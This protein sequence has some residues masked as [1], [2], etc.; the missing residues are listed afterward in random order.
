VAERLDEE[1]AALR[2][3]PPGRFEPA[4]ERAVRVPIDG[5]LKHAGSFYRA[6][7]KLVH[8]RVALRFSRD[9]IWICHRGAEV[10]RYRRSYER[11]TWL[12]APVVRPEPPPARAPALL[13]TI[14]I[15]PPELAPY[16]ELVR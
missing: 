8:Q 11:G 15:P 5:Y 12:P 4:G 13:P 3:L 10:A 6:P 1:R 9:E 14:A 2:P 7:A 16:A